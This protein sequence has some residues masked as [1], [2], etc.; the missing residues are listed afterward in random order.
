MRKLASLMLI[1]LLLAWIPACKGKPARKPVK[2][3]AKKV[4]RA[5]QKEENVVIPSKPEI[6]RIKKV[7]YN[8]TGRRDP[9][10]SIVSLTKQ[11]VQKK[12][13]KSLNPLENY[14]VADFRL[15]GVIY[16]GKDYYASILLPDGKAFTV[17]KGMKLGL[18]GGS[19]IDVSP[20]SLVIRE[21]V[22]NYKG[23]LKPKDTV[24]KLRK[25]EE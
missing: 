4:S 25:E 9:F 12:R 21:Y 16:D 14:D 20:D 19:I 23:E 15:L 13:K 3:P 6:F 10:L 1:V 24:L 18:Y 17:K 2:T 11:K 8:P 22:M 7:E 5:A